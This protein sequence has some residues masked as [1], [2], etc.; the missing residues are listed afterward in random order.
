MWKERNVTTD[1]AASASAGE[2]DAQRVIKAY[3]RRW[4]AQLLAM[5]PVAISF[6]FL[7]WCTDNGPDLILGLAR[8]YWLVASATLLAALLI[9]TFIN[10]RCPACGQR[11]GGRCWHP[12]FCPNCGATLRA[13]RVQHRARRCTVAQRW[14][15]AAGGILTKINGE[16]FDCLTSQCGARMHR[17]SLKEWWGIED[18]MSLQRT[19]DWLFREGHSASFRTS[20]Q[21]GAIARRV[22]RQVQQ[23]CGV[24]E[25]PPGWFTAATGPKALVGWDLTRLINVTRWAYTA[26]YIDEGLAWKWTL[27]ASRRLQATFGSW[28]EAGLNFCIGWAYWNSE[29]TRGEYQ[30]GD[31]N[32][33]VEALTA[34]NWLT[35]ATDSPWQKLDWNTDLSG[36]TE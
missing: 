15:L 25:V 34:F 1:P 20:R 19:K 3:A 22:T 7:M 30:R 10:W 9:F 26:G 18:R 28:S 36:Q 11:L 23:M 8:T 32:L 14:G 17:G 33:P 31:S 5:P 4:R 6:W 29:V 13:D 24:A 21:A 27:E 16:D 2:A 12:S 35:M